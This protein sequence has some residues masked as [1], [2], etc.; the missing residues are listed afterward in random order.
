MAN[1]YANL[2]KH[3]HDRAL[4]LLRNAEQYEKL[5]KNKILQE[6][7]NNATTE[8]DRVY[9]DHTSFQPNLYLNNYS[10]LTDLKENKLIIKC[11]NLL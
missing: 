9:I 2:Q 5:N 1:E 6:I 3:L 7:M 10:N 11:S 4:N 8:L